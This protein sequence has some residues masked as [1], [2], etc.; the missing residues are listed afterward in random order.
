MNKRSAII[1]LIVVALAAFFYPKDTFSSG[2]FLGHGTKYIEYRCFGFATYPQDTL[3]ATH[4]RC[5]GIP[6]RTDAVS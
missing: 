6:Y 1:L 3:D 4:M 5:F 2:F